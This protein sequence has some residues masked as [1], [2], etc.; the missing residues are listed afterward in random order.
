MLFWHDKVTYIKVAFIL[1]LIKRKREN[2]DKTKGFSVKINCYIFIDKISIIVH[3]LIANVRLFMKQ[4]RIDQKKF[5]ILY[6]YCLLCA[7]NDTN[8]L[9]YRL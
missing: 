2:V 1:K 3:I 6:I 4:E 8:D 7:Q 5:H 9:F